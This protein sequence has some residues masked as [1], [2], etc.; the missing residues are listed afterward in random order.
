MVAPKRAASGKAL[1]HQYLE[2]YDRIAPISEA[3][4]GILDEFGVLEVSTFPS[5]KYHPYDYM[6]AD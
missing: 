3:R 6:S 4:F 5:A 2:I 1:K